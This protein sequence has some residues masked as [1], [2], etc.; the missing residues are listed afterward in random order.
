MR[1][2]RTVLWGAF[3]VVV[4]LTLPAQAE[5]PVAGQPPENV[6]AGRVL[7]HAKKP[8]EGATVAVIT[9]GE[10]FMFYRA[11]G[12]MHLWV[13]DDKLW[14]LFTRRNGKRSAKTTTDADGKFE[15]RSLHEGKYHV[16]AVHPERGMIV[17]PDVR[18]PNADK[19]VDIELTPPTFVRG[20]LSG[21]SD[22]GQG[23]YC[24]A[25]QVLEEG[26]ENTPLSHQ[27]HI[28]PGTLAK[29]DGEFQIGPL[30]A[31]GKWRL[32]VQ[33]FV[34]K[35]SFAA[36]LIEKNVSLAEGKS[37]VVDLSKGKTSPITGQI[38]GP[39][40]KPLRDVSVTVA[41]KDADGIDAT[42]GALTDKDGKY[43][44]PWL[45]DGKL[46]LI[47]QRWAPRAGFG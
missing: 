22:A 41:F 21:W 36:S 31:G 3:F 24:G 42:H 38:H 5:E 15:I 26:A 46:K 47:A 18:Q 12:E 10:G 43:T 44:V 14:G 45:P 33:R 16:L 6:F 30:P 29:K 28:N 19:P 40:G 37:N 8:V 35:R 39:D 32:S 4:E 7:D 17:V 27:V 2:K 11:P 9:T 25:R 34:P 20:T 23:C 1:V 13:S